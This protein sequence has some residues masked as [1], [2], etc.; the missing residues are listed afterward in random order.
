MQKL[1][2]IMVGG[3]RAEVSTLWEDNGMWENAGV[4]GMWQYEKGQERMCSDQ[5][6]KWINKL[7]NGK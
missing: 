6:I 1:D 2:L 5:D 4:G 7:I 3:Y